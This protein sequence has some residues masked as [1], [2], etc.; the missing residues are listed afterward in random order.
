[1]PLLLRGCVAKMQRAD[2]PLSGRVPWS[3]SGQGSGLKQ[4][5]QRVAAQSHF[6]AL[7]ELENGWWR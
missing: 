2:L 3:E 7:G 4:E 6:W 1:M 5:V